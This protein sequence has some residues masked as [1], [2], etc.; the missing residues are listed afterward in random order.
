M[1]FF[2]AARRLLK[3]VFCKIDANEWELEEAMNQLCTYSRTLWEAVAHPAVHATNENQYS[4]TTSFVSR[5]QQ[6]S[7]RS[8]ID[9]HQAHPVPNANKL[10]DSHRENLAK[11]IVHVTGMLRSKELETSGIRCVIK[12]G[13]CYVYVIYHIIHIPNSIAVYY[14]HLFY[15]C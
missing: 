13:V 5:K 7:L 1:S 8:G 9:S 15:I 14:S 4:K 6:V 3:K 11:Q 10:V 12:N 2:E